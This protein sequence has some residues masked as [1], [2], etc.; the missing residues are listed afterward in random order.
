M[1]PTITLKKW[2]RLL[3]PAWWF[4]LFLYIAFA[5]L[6]PLPLERSA[7][8]AGIIS[9][10]AGL[11]AARFGMPE[12]AIQ[13]GLLLSLNLWIF[14]AVSDSLYP[15]S[16]AFLIIPILAA[17]FYVDPA[18][19]LAVTIV[20]LPELMFSARFSP[21]SGSLADYPALGPAVLL[22][23]VL[24][25]IISLIHASSYQKI[26]REIEEKNRSM[27]N[28]LLSREGYLQLFFGNAKDAIAVFDLDDRVIDINPSFEELYGWSRDEAIG[29][30][31]PIVPPE[32]RGAASIR[33]K[34]LY[35]GKSYSLLE[36]T[37]MRK[38][39]SRFP[40]EL[41][42]SPIFDAEGR[43]IATSA[44]SRDISYRKET[45]NL[46][47][48][49]EKLKLAGEM[50]AGVAHE[51]RNPL[52]VISGFVQM[53]HHDADH[54]YQSFTKLILSEIERIN[55]IISEFLILAKPQA[56]QFREVSLR[57]TLQEVFLLY[58]PEFN[59][60]G[61]IFHE[62]WRHSDYVV[63]GEKNQL[64]QVFINLIRNA[65]EAVGHEGK[66]SLLVEEREEGLVAVRLRDNGEGIPDDVLKKIFEPFYTTKASG[67]GLGLIISQRIVQ[68][69]GGSLAIRSKE[70]KGTEVTVL[71]PITSKQAAQL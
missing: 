6:T 46:I 10:L 1:D 28:A 3:L 41:T 64:K 48:Q 30:I 21:V 2:N 56:A 31:L 71:L 60:Q 37:D 14:L 26:W 33:L 51:V 69:H 70:R 54:P 5:L 55:L 32:N 35:E 27:E 22:L 23:I 13:F 25:S 63:N 49:S 50:A 4:L 39:G 8:A 62:T 20:T 45:E 12:R 24:A 9:G 68:D 57:E 53:M 52:T 42:L 11:A 18:P 17:A 36:T 66:I 67:T 40:A 65:I 29:R 47:V 61:I 43:V 19:V 59:M 44:I 34:N 16:F 15:I 38:D 58:G 7:A